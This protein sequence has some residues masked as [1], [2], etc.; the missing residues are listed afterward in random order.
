MEA[1]P[2]RARQAIEQVLERFLSDLRPDLS[3]ILDQLD[4]AVIRRARNERDDAML[5]QWVDTREALGRR[6][7]GFIPAFNEAL[8]RECESAH[9]HAAPSLSRGLLGDQLQPLMLLDEHI[10]D[11]DNA[12]AALAS[13]HASRASLPL[14]LLGHRFAVL[15]ERPPLDAAALPI[16]PEACCRALRS[17]AQAIDLP[18]HARIVLY[19]AYDNEVGR[20]YEACIQTANAMLDEAG[21]LPGLS[22]VPLR[23]R[24][25][26]SHPGRGQVADAPGAA[27]DGL[28]SAIEAMRIVNGTL[29]ELAPPGTLPESCLPERAEAVAAMVQLVSRFGPGSPEWLRCRMVVAEVVDAIRAGNA[30]DPAIREWIAGSLAMVGYSD[31]DAERLSTALVDMGG[32]GVQG[33]AR[34]ARR[35]Q[36]RL[37][38]LPQGTL[39]GFSRDGGIVRARLRDHRRDTHSVLL[40]SEDS[41]QEAWIDSDTVS[42]LLANGQAWLLTGTG[43]RR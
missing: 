28:L 42:R 34:E 41:G 31:G 17:A 11:E 10:V 12:L 36:A 26:A 5:V 37:D 18:I 39:I 15:L 38:A 27:S 14:M 6:K 20:H 22:F 8:R 13:R 4:A 29:D 9:D 21:I 33:A 23:A 32:A 25:G 3:V 24:A 1:I 40:A 19:N 2:R 16:G 30:I 7:D 43:G 35:W